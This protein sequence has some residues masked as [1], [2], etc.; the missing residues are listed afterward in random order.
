MLFD[1]EVDDP[2]VALKE[3]VFVAVLL[4]NAKMQ[5]AIGE[6]TAVLEMSALAI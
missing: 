1:Q 6:V 2:F 4:K 3:G 5:P